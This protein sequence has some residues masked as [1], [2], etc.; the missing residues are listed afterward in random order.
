MSLKDKNEENEE[1]FE[2]QSDWDGDHRNISG[3][4]TQLRQE[5]STNTTSFDFL[6]K[7]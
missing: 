3:R 7:N 1:K 4:E 6:K 5:Q 2:I